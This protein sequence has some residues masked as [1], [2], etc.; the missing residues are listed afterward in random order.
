MSTKREQHTLTDY[1]LQQ[2][3]KQ[4]GEEVARRVETAPSLLRAAEVALALI[5]PCSAPSHVVRCANFGCQIR[6]ILESA[7]AT[8]AKGAA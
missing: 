5:P 4:Y 2:I 8:A 7:I 1:D 3:S 6:R